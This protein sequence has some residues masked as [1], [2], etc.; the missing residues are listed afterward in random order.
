[1]QN[2][3]QPAMGGICQEL[4]IAAQSTTGTSGQLQSGVAQAGSKQDPFQGQHFLSRGSPAQ[5]KSVQVLMVVQISAAWWFFHHQWDF[6]KVLGQ[7]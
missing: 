3:N 5:E 7:F 6:Y 2:E 1:M 4:S